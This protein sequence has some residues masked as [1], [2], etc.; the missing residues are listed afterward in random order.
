MFKTM[1]VDMG[2]FLVAI[3]VDKVVA[4]SGYIIQLFF[5]FYNYIHQ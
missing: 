5:I 3:V 4:Q 1:V 2:V